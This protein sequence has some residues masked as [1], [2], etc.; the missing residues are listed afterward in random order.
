VPALEQLAPATHAPALQL[1]TLFAG[2]LGA[3]PVPEH[4]VCPGPHTPLHSPL[5]QLWFAGQAGTSSSH[6][7]SVP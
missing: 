5:T 6:A 2:A 4:A 7:D 3:P 1:Q